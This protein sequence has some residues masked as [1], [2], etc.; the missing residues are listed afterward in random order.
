M[1]LLRELKEKIFS[2]SSTPDSTNSQSITSSFSKE[3]HEVHGFY[4][5]KQLWDIILCSEFM[6][7]TNIKPRGY[8]GDSEMM[9]MIYENTY[10]G[11]TTFSKILNKFSINVPAAQSVRNRR[12]KIP[13]I[14]HKVQNE[15]KRQEGGLLRLMSVACGPAYELSDLFLSA[16]DAEKFHCTLLDQDSEALEEAGERI[17]IVEKKFDCK[18]NSTYLKDSVRTM[19]RTHDLHKIWGRFDFI[20]SMGLFDYLTQ[21]VAKAV[22][23]KIYSLLEPGGYLLIGN[24]H[25]SNKSRW[26]MEYWLDWVLY[27]R[28]DEDMINL[29]ARHGCNQY[30]DRR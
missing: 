13:Q 26:F 24:Y 8:A 6:A 3:E 15:M 23:E 17:A 12:I 29:L 25:Y 2:I 14:L 1:K 20:Y 21:P 10:T 19:I 7:R 11:D 27:Y 18:I 9:R 30:I 5:R 16:A 22:I 28:S 4:L